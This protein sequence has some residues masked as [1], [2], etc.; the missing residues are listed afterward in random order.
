MILT[1]H[2]NKLCKKIKLNNKND[3]DNNN[4]KNK[5]IINY[6][7]DSVIDENDNLIYNYRLV[8]G[9]SNIKGGIKVLK[10]LEYPEDMI[11]KINID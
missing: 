11:D 6:K 5:K 2:Y 8:T 4:N 3:N 9:I 10:Q 7:M 1:T